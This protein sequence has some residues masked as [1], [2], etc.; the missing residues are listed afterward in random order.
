L[1]DNRKPQKTIGVLFVY[2]VLALLIYFGISGLTNTQ[3]VKDISYSE[4]ISFIESKQVMNIDIEDTGM[5]SLKL[6]DGTK[7]NVYNPGMMIDQDFIYALSRDGIKI[8]FVK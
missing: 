8:R 4:M 1:A 3:S 2:I 5:M 6:I 7:Y